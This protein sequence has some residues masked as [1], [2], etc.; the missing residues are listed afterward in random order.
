MPRALPSY[1]PPRLG[2][3]RPTAAEYGRTER[4]LAAN[5]FYASVAW[6]RLRAAFLAEHP[7][8]H[9]CRERGRLVPANEVHHINDRIAYPMLALQWNNL[10][11]LCKVC[12]SRR[13]CR[14]AR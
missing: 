1:R 10:M 11:S 6:R 14:H 12:H 2:P 4:R 3:P 7:L 8:C 9:D 5:R 13:G